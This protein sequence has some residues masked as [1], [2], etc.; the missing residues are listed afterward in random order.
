MARKSSFWNSFK[1]ET[2]KNTG[3][4]LSNKI[5]G[6]GW[7]TPSRHEISMAEKRLT[8]NQESEHTTNDVDITNNINIKNVETNEHDIEIE[9]I[10]N[11]RSKEFWRETIQQENSKSK[12]GWIIA[13]GITL[14]CFGLIYM[15]ANHQIAKKTNDADLQLS[16]E[17]KEIQVLQLISSDKKEEALELVMELNHPSEEQMPG[18]GKISDM[19]NQTSYKNYWDLKREALKTRILN[20]E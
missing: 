7:S 20:I 18:S 2:G 12:R 11:E 1:R 5:F 6:N 14:L 10:R 19:F 9:K 15:M 8:E 16:L 3:K 13:I 17:Q 4:W